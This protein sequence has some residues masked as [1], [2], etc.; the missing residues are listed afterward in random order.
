[1]HHLDSKIIKRILKN[2]IKISK[3]MKLINKVAVF[4]EELISLENKIGNLVIYENLENDVIKSLKKGKIKITK[5]EFNELFFKLMA[6]GLILV[7]KEGFIIRTSNW[8][9]SHE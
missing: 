3:D 7:P 6:T 4:Y 2:P 9:S 8:R 5:K 1:M